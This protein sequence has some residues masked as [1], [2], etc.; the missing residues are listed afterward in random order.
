MTVASSRF[1][2]LASY[3]EAKHDVRI[4]SKDTDR[5]A[6]ELLNLLWRGIT[7]GHGKNLLK[8]YVMT[9]G[10]TIYF[11]LGWTQE[12]AD[13]EDYIILC[14]ELKHI[15]QYR[16][17][18]FGSEKLGFAIF[19]LLYLLVPLPLGLAWFRYAFERAAYLESYKAAKDLGLSPKIDYYVGI[20]SGVTYFWAWPFK[21]L[22]RRWF[23]QRCK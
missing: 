20:L 1:I 5:G 21:F 8:N 18:G 4:R 12:S 15:E 13:D 3:F 14:H 2:R 6:W 7:F 23:M 10:R 22:I 17:L 11:P 9:V 19:A 16:T